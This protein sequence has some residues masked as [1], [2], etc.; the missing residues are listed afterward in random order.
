ML[1]VRA[2]NILWKFSDSLFSRPPHNNY[3][4]FIE[5]CSFKMLLQFKS[6]KKY[7]F[8]SLPLAF[9]R[10]FLTKLTRSMT[11]LVVFA[12][13]KSGQAVKW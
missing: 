10:T 6:Q 3:N 5:N 8:H 12:T 11:D 4:S 9:K 13:P 1:T 7:T 2:S